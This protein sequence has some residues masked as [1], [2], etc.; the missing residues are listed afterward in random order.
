MRDDSVRDIIIGL[1]A[2]GLA[3]LITGTLTYYRVKTR[4]DYSGRHFG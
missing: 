3:L 1:L 2:V 4:V